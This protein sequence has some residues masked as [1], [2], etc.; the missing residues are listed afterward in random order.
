[1]VT[2]VIKNFILAGLIVFECEVSKGIRLER[3]IYNKILV[4]TSTKWE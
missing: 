1:M 2:M 4:E 3:C